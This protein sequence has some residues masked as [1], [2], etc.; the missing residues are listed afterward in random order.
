M[1]KAAML[2]SS[3]IKTLVVAFL[4][5]VAF[6]AG[7]VVPAQADATGTITYVEGSTQAT[8]TVTNPGS[9]CYPASRR[10]SRLTNNTNRAVTV[11]TASGSCSRAPAYT[12]SPGGHFGGEFLSF[13]SG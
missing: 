6:S 10:S 11:Y 7:A 12:V 1:R 3:K 9:D 13:R 2:P 5:S 4:G 8:V